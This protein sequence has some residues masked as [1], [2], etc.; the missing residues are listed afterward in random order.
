MLIEVYQYA[1]LLDPAFCHS[2][3]IQNWNVESLPLSLKTLN[4][5]RMFHQHTIAFQHQMGMIY[6]ILVKICRSHLKSDPVKILLG[7]PMYHLCDNNMPSMRLSSPKNDQLRDFFSLN[8][9]EFLNDFISTLGTS[10]PPNFE[11]AIDVC[12]INDGNNVSCRIDSRIVAS[13]YGR[14]VMKLIN[15][16]KMHQII[17]K[18]WKLNKHKSIFPY[19]IRSSRVGK[20]P[21]PIT[22]SISCWHRRSISGC[23]WKRCNRNANCIEFALSAGAIKSWAVSINCLSGI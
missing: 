6:P 10:Y 11:S 21:S 15:E 1:R 8:Q 5:A 19:L 9:V 12:G 4:F 14:L 2:S 17:I 7:D 22:V 3:V 18:S 20:R 23:K 13:T 16:R